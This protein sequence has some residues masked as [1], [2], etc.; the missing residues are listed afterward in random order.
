MSPHAHVHTLTHT[1]TLSVI[2]WGMGVLTDIIVGITSY[3]IYMYLIVMM[4]TLILYMLYVIYISVK[5]GSQGPDS[6]GKW[7]Q[8]VCACEA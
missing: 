6:G 7:L 3:N 8:G 5:L 4:H 2:I 1:H